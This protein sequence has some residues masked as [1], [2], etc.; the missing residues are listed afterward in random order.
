M[1]DHENSSALAHNDTRHADNQQG[2]EVLSPVIVSLGKKKRK[3]IKRLK[4]GKGRAM[5]DVLDV[6]EQVQMNLGEQAA[7]KIIL[8]VIVVYRQKERRFRRFF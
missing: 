7:G 5:D 3:A 2:A 6:I 8:P 4:R 1:I